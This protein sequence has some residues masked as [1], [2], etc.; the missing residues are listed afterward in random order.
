MDELAKRCSSPPGP[1]QVRMAARL[2]E[3]AGPKHQRELRA[4]RGTG[5]GVAWGHLG[6]L[7][8]AESKSK[9]LALPTSPPGLA[10]GRLCG[11]FMEVN[12]SWMP[13]RVVAKSTGSDG[14]ASAMC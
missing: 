6:F 5:A 11:C 4:V 14:S 12:N 10:Q 3:L 13:H 1:E 8:K 7:G 2:R 9:S